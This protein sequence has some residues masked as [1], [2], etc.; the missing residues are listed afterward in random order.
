M[1]NELNPLTTLLQSYITWLLNLSPGT[2]ATVTFYLFFAIFVLVECNLPREKHLSKQVQQS[3]RTNLGLFIFNSIVMT[4]LSVPALLMLAAHTADKGVLNAVSNPVLKAVLSFLAI[5]LLLYFLHKACHTFDC[6]WMFHKVHHNDPYLNV[7]TAFR[8]HFLEI[9]IINLMKA[10][11]IVVLGIGGALLL[12][13]ETITTVFTMLHHT[14]IT[15]RGEQFLSRVMITP[16]LH[17][18]HHS[19][20]RHEHDRNYGAVLSIWDRWFGTVAVLKPVAIGLQGSLPQGL[21]K[22]VIYG[23]TRTD[24]SSAH[25][26][27]LEDR[28]A[29][30]AYYKAEKR[31]FYPGNELQDWLEAK[32]DI[33]RGDYANK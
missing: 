21:I 26:V 16:Y 7:S 14:N 4:L 5:D 32:R 11:L 10:V 22:L 17:R 23:L 12:V 30:A 2:V 25:P 28:I 31:G 19:T 15:F 1:L 13:N 33:I 6:L 3:Y 9:L 27:R 20:Q 29:E 24:N 8:L 18:V